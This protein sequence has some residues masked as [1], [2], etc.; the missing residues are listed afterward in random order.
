MKI[1]LFI[2]WTENSTNNI[3]K[4]KK[5]FCMYPV[6]KLNICK[7]IIKNIISCLYLAYIDLIIIK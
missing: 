4:F 6:H 5:I 7:K 2:V 1:Y 3:L